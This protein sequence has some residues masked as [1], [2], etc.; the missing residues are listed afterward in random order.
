MNFQ[1]HVYN[2]VS[3]WSRKRNISYN[4]VGS[5]KSNIYTCIAVELAKTQNAPSR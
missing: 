5:V 4:L 2:F 1:V 3:V